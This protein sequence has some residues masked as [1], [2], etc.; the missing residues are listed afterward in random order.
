MRTKKKKKNVKNLF[1]YSNKTNLQFGRSSL[2]IAL[3]NRYY[4]IEKLIKSKLN[5]D[6]I[7]II[8]YYENQMRYVKD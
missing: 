2:N 7:S 3:K 4:D 8:D 6:F 1:F 5:G